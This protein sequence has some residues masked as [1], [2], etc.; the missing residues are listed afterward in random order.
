MGMKR[1]R[2]CLKGSLILQPIYLAPA[3]S[4]FT[5]ALY[6]QAEVCAA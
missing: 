2:I 3:S 4:V 5:V 1:R 6:R